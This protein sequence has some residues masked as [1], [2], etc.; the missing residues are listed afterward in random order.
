VTAKD[1]RTVRCANCDRA[2]ALKTDYVGISFVA[3]DVWILSFMLAFSFHF[4]AGGFS[5]LAAEPFIHTKKTAWMQ[6]LADLVR[7]GHVRYLSGEVP[8]ERAQDLYSKFRAIYPSIA[9]THVQSTRA[10]K[11]GESTARLLFYWPGEGRIAWVLLRTEGQLPP[12]AQDAREKWR[13]AIKDRLTAPGGY[14]LVRLTK[15]QEPK[16]V[17]TWRYHRDQYS[18]HR[19]SIREAIRNRRDDQLRQLIHSLWRTP[20]FAGARAQ[21]KQLEKLIRADWKRVRHSSEELPEIPKHLGY[22]Q[23][24]A[25]KG[26]LLSKLP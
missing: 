21:V 18:K 22:V 26:K 1:Y 24:L 10:R 20:G 2:H 15:P 17:W 19:D 4:Y 3:L 23:R 6:R 5:V 14:E 11:K 9:F 13:D 7:S 12:A 25:D 16:P 8:R